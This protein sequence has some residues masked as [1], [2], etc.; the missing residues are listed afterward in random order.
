VRGRANVVRRHDI[1]YE[2]VHSAID[3]YSRIAYSELLPAEDAECC[4]GFL[5]R[6]HR[7]APM[8]HGSKLA[9]RTDARDLGQRAVTATGPG[10]YATAPAVASHVSRAARLSIAPLALPVTASIQHARAHP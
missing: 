10:V 3:A 7:Q 6:A 4:T 9:K 1:G 5:E 8:Q 2:H